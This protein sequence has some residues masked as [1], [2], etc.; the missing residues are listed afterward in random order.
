MLLILEVT[1]FT[2][3][4]PL[5]GSSSSVDISTDVESQE[6]HKRG[7]GHET[8]LTHSPLVT[9]AVLETNNIVH[10]PATITVAQ[11]PVAIA[12][13]PMTFAHPPVTA[14][15]GHLAVAQA[16]ILVPQQV[17]AIPA[18]NHHAESYVYSSGPD[19]FYQVHQRHHPHSYY[20]PQHYYPSFSYPAATSVLTYPSP[21]TQYGW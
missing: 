13:A 21:V 15:H 4:I 6:R 1:S 14:T 19:Y 7:W 16:P 8:T 5:E 12:Q 10:N 18:A 9:S 3:S 11:A 20:Y 17:V 2:T